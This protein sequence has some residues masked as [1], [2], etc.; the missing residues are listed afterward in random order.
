MRIDPSRPI[1]PNRSINFSIS[2]TD[3]FTDRSVGIVPR[4]GRLLPVGKLTQRVA[5]KFPT[6]IVRRQRS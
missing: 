3:R 4:K 5:P 6:T 2:P 1:E